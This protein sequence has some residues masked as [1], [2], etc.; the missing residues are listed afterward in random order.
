MFLRENACDDLADHPHCRQNHDVDR[1]MRVEPEEVLEEHRVAAER[2]IED[3]HVQHAFR[4][5]EEDRDRDDRCSQD[6]DQA[7]RV[8]RP[9]EERKPEPRQPRRAHPVHGDD[10]V[11][12][13][14]DRREAGDEHAERSHDDVRVGGRRAVRRV[15]RPARVHPAA[16]RR[17]ER[18]RAA[19]NVDVPAEQVDSRKRQ[20][21]RPDH[22]REQEVP[23]RGGDRRNQEEEDHHH[24]VHGEHL[25]VALGGEEIPRG[26]QQLQADEQR[27]EPAHRR[28]TPSRRPGRAA[29]SACGLSSTARTRGRGRC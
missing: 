1:R 6:H 7:R 13:R 22:D 18:E 26:R 12:P 10:E 2:R 5:D 23:E 27:E 3:P 11:Q 8:V 29:R 25:V 20:I 17:R 19:Q 9:H 21:L 15:E 16:Q 14:E 4:R 28:R 24:A